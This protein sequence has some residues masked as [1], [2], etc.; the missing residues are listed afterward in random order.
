MTVF[1][2]YDGTPITDFD[3]IH[4]VNDTQGKRD[5]LDASG[6]TTECVD[7]NS[8]SLDYYSTILTKSITTETVGS[9][10]IN[11]INVNHAENLNGNI[12]LK[13]NLSTTLYAGN[14]YIMILEPIEDANIKTNIIN[15]NFGTTK[16]Y[17]YKDGFCIVEDIRRPVLG[18]GDKK[19]YMYKLRPQAALQSIIINL[20]TV[21]KISNAVKPIIKLSIKTI[22]S[23]NMDAIAISTPES[24]GFMSIE[25]K[26]KLDEINTMSNYIE[27][28][29]ENALFYSIQK[30]G[31]LTTGQNFNNHLKK[32]GP[33][34]TKLVFTNTAISSDNKSSATLVSDSNSLNA[35]YMYLDGD[36]IYVSPE[37][38][39]VNIFANASCSYMFKATN[40]VSIDFSNFNTSNVIYMNEMFMDSS[41]LT[42]ID[43][44][45]FN[46]SKVTDMGA[47]FHNCESFTSI[48]ILN[49]DTSN[50]QHTSHMFYN[51]NKLTTI[52]IS[53]FNTPKLLNVN[54]MF[55][56]CPSLTTIIGL[57]NFNT[58]NVTNMN[59]L[60][61][62]CDNLTGS[63]TIM[64]SN[65]SQYLNMFTY[66]SILSSAKFTVNYK[67]GCQ[68]LAQNMVNTKSSNSN[69]V[70]GTLIS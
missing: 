26:Y 50:V 32:V 16:P 53:N 20:Y 1:K 4:T 68:T 5:V 57:E 46:T 47:M 45:N 49:F 39:E 66:C 70:L 2:R 42:T 56:L 17:S 51:C 54:S 11:V 63:I 6:T 65:I 22:N 64:N 10:T 69:V 3:H 14:T 34:A 67:E 31:M 25:D 8:I 35:V 62:S 40:L 44:S 24:T 55:A 61:Y 19:L 37:N 59:Y 15:I 43:I 27:S 29:L 28:K 58:V 13:A 9:K 33:N 41:K 18:Y 52:D 30:V 12:V 38:D 60:F 48:N 36:T 21:T 23:T 7:T